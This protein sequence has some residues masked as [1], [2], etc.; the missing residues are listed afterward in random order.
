MHAMQSQSVRFGGSSQSATENH[1]VLAIR[2]HVFLVGRRYCRRCCSFHYL[3]SMAPW[4]SRKDSIGD[5]GQS[6]RF[7]AGEQQRN[8][9]S[10]E[11]K[12]NDFNVFATNVN[13]FD[14]HG[15]SNDSRIAIEHDGSRYDFHERSA[16]NSD[17]VPSRNSSTR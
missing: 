16:A 4:R 5:R 14:A 17:A 7:N 11:T 1:P 2:W 8:A 3:A 15:I 9:S 12:F 6:T 13:L 10:V